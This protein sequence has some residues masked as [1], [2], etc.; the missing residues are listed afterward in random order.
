MFSFFLYFWAKLFCIAT[1]PSIHNSLIRNILLHV[2]S[3]IA[4]LTVLRLHHFDVQVIMGKNTSIC[5]TVVSPLKNFTRRF[6]CQPEIVGSVVKI[7][8]DKDVNE[9]LTICEVEVYGVYGKFMLLTVVYC[10]LRIVF[11]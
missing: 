11:E 4:L 1:Y 8:M 9:P 5:A 2:I 6:Q 7:Q 3:N 10:S